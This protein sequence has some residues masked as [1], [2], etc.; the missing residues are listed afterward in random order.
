MGKNVCGKSFFELLFKRRGETSIFEEEKY[1]PERKTLYLKIFGKRGSG[2][3]NADKGS[4]YCISP[5]NFNWTYTKL[6]SLSSREEE[7]P[8]RSSLKSLPNTTPCDM[9]SSRPISKYTNRSQ[10]DIIIICEQLF[11]QMVHSEIPSS[12]VKLC[13]LFDSGHSNTIPKSKDEVG[14]VQKWEP[15][16]Q[17]HHP[18]SHGPS[19][20]HKKIFDSIPA[21][22]IV[23]FVL[24][25]GN[26]DLL[27]WIFSAA[28][29]FSE[30]F[31]I[32]ACTFSE[33]KDVSQTMDIDKMYNTAISLLRSLQLVHWCSMNTPQVPQFFRI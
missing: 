33:N 13:G 15:I 1:T 31:K 20:H 27:Q 6:L 28:I 3:C 2:S 5:K 12:E 17:L 19:H 7:M 24:T 30:M 10:I 22:D 16:G 11:V 26:G 8:R 9:W 23:R 18:P 32:V 4:R 25:I 29:H 14:Q 21:V